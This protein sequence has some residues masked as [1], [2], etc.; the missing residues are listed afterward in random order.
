MKKIFTVTK[1]LFVVSF[2]FVG[3]NV[4]AANCSVVADKLCQVFNEITAQV[5]KCRTIDDM[6]NI[7]VD[8]ILNNVN[9]DD[10]DEACIDAKIE[11]ADKARI[12][13]SIDNWVNAMANK[14]ADFSGGMFSA[15]GAK[16]MLKPMSDSLKGA[17][18]RSKTYND[19][20]NNLNNM[21][22]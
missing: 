17:I 13:K 12:N 4:K 9:I 21:N 1:L 19:L 10:L 16:E 11:A 5:N 7:N 22:F 6:D 20:L 2:M 14:L 8:Q 18:D 15:S 3:F